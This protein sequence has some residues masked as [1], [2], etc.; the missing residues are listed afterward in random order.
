MSFL[1]I[2]PNIFGGM[3][4][5]KFCSNCGK[6]TEKCKCGDQTIT[7]SLCIP[8]ELLNL[9]NLLPRIQISSDRCHKCGHSVNRCTCD[10]KVTVE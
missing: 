4:T 10:E 2:N 9:V 3:G 6:E 7:I 8:R 1:G 5:G